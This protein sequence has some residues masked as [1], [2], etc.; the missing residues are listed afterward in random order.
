VLRASETHQPQQSAHSPGPQWQTK[1]RLD[2]DKT[3]RINVPV[4]V[5]GE[6]ST[7]PAKPEIDSVEA[8]LPDAQILVLA[9]QRHIA[10]I[11]NP[12]TFAVH[13]LGFLYN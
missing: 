13:L 11:L 5:T 9:G 12:A 8:A 3:A 4:L 1:A 2:A 6:E 7:D 10:D